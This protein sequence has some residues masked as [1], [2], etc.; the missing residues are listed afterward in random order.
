M[1]SPTRYSSVANLAE[2]GYLSVCLIAVSVGPGIVF[3]PGGRTD[4]TTL[5]SEVNNGLQETLVNLRVN[6]NEHD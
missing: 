4:L 6:M 5:I 2:G 3:E 1:W